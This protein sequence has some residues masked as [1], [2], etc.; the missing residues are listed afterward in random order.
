MHCLILLPDGIG[1]RNFIISQFPQALQEMGVERITVG[2]ALPDEN[3]LPI[4]GHPGIRWVKL[5]AHREGHLPFIF[6]R[7]KQ[8]AQ[9]YWQRSFVPGTDVILR[10]FTTRRKGLVGVRAA[11]ANSLGRAFSGGHQGVRA[12]NDLHMKT[13][14]R[15]RYF[16]QYLQLLS[17]EKPDVVFCSHQR[18]EFAVPCMLAAKRLGIPTATFIYSW[19]NLPKGRMAVHADYYLVWSEHMRAEMHTYYPDVSDD[20]IYVIGTPQFEHYFNPTLIEPRVDFLGRYGLDPLRPV[21][22]YSGDDLTTSP[23]DQDYLADLAHAMRQISADERPQILF[24]RNPTDTQDRYRRG[25]DE[26]SE[27]VDA[28]PQWVKL[29]D[30]DWSKVVPSREDLCLLVN[31]VAHCDLVINVGSTMAVDFAVLGKPAIY[32]AYN[33]KSR[34]ENEKWHIDN[35]YRYPHFN[36]INNFDPVHWATSSEELGSLVMRVL[37]NP[38][39]KAKNRQA[40]LEFLVRHPLDQAN[41]RCAE[42]LVDI[43]DRDRIS[44]KKICI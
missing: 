9:L 36:P 10:G 42:A 31:T 19:D 13:V 43:V 8:I 32:L 11:L 37:H 35:V 20:H 27:I 26:Y 17:R 44:E 3:L 24:R 22:C 39:E 14:T 4:D 29:A 30:N 6:R 7:A 16:S 18:S 2:H 40:W 5:P 33:P 12:L 21:V 15:A 28:A 34:R 23:H 41:Q 25:L 1:I 38:E